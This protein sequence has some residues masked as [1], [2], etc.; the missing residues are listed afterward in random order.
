MQNFSLEN[1]FHFH[2]NELVGEM[3]FHNNGFTGTL[4]QMESRK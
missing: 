3:H 2:E 4:K 1:E